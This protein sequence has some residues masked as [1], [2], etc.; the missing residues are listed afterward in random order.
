MKISLVLGS[1]GARGYAQIGVIHELER[2]GHE[3]VAIAGASAGALIGGLYAAGKLD[4]F[5]AKARTFTPRQLF[6]MLRPQL[7]APG[8]IRLTRV[9]EMLHEITG[10][11]DI[12]D[13]PIPY[14]A[15][16]T[17]L[18]ARREIWF[19][20]GPLLPAIR[21][22][23]AIPTIFS[24]VKVRGRLLCDGGLVNPLPMET[25]LRWDADL[26]VAVSLFGQPSTGLLTSVLD[27]PGTEPIEEDIEE[28]AEA[29]TST[30]AGPL[31]W[32]G[33]WFAGAAKRP[34]SVFEP[35]PATVDLMAMMTTA[36]DIMQTRIQA[37]RLAVNPP[38]VLIEV[39][40]DC[41]GTFDFAEADTIIS[42]GETLAVEVFDNAGI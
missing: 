28:S 33:S 37:S 27:A 1:G 11:V 23:I 19:H 14:T 2:R 39:P 12:E 41:G 35:L 36:L 29:D 3:I 7:G 8:L 25:S 18:Q 5:E 4:E 22:S 30:D 10:D 20:E 32:L 6:G 13:L 9:M 15:V 24:P 16:A 38:D 40:V 31:D 34:P 42:L 26:T 17:D 21:A